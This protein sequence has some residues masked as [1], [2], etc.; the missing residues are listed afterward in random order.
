MQSL[1]DYADINDLL[2]V[3]ETL[4][5]GAFKYDED[6]IEIIRAWSNLYKIFE[7]TQDKV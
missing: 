2:I 5:K 4:N 6:R 7:E 1:V 3:L